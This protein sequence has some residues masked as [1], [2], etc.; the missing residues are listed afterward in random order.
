MSGATF[1][2]LVELLRW[3][4]AAV[5]VALALMI[6]FR[7]SLSQAIARLRRVRV[8]GFDAETSDVTK[9][10]VQAQASAKTDSSEALHPAPAKDLGEPFMSSI[11]VERTKVLLNDPQYKAITD[12]AEK[13]RLLARIIASLQYSLS[14]E[15][16]FQVIFRS[17]IVALRVCNNSYGPLPIANVHAIYA[18]AVP[19]LDRLEGG[20]KFD[21][22]LNFI[23]VYAEFLRIDGDQ[24][25]ITDLGREFLKY[26][27]ERRY[28]EATKI[29]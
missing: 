27:I 21:R 3:P 7:S 15:Q 2:K 28:S 16:T 13:E 11:L 5:F 8:P 10:Q 12:Q 23:T 18:T 20:Y 24:V 22:W 19:P 14:F 4:A 29:H 1:I 17:Q 26:L 9:E 25:S 6:V